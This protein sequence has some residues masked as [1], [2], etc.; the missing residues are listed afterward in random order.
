M[1]KSKKVYNELTQKFNE[2]LKVNNVIA[3]PISIHEDS[4]LENKIKSFNDE[5][6]IVV[7][8]LNPSSSEQDDKI[9]DDGVLHYLPKGILKEEHGL[10][11]SN[12]K[13]KNR[14]LFYEQYFKK[15]YELFFEHNYL[16]YWTHPQIGKELL[17]EKLLEKR[18]DQLEFKMLSS[19][20]D[21]ERKYKCVYFADMLPVRI[22]NSSFVKS[23]LNQLES[24]IKLDFILERINHLINIYNPKLI[25]IN[26]AFVSDLLFETIFEN[27]SDFYTYKSINNNKTTLVFSSIM[28]NGNLDKYS[29]FRLKNEIRKLLK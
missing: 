7:L 8:G 3:N 11:Y 23:F 16:P 1:I 12:L 9:K 5:N 28:S 4:I 21:F 24:S 26:N 18:I 13:K 25:F 2:Y 15:P 6:N 27:E 17:Y 19:Y 20:I 22:T 14:K 29:E 10:V